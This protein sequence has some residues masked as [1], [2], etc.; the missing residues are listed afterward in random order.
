MQQG[1]QQY[2]KKLTSVGFIFL[3][4]VEHEIII[5]NLSIT[6]LF[7]E[8]SP[9][10][11]L[12]DIHDLFASI[13][14]YSASVDLVIP[15]M[16]LAAEAEVVRADMVDGLIYMGLE[17]KNISYDVEGFIY[18]RESYRKK[19]DG[20]GNIEFAGQNYQFRTRNVSVDGLMILINESVVLEEGAVAKFDFPKL[21]LKGEVEVIWKDYD[22]DG[23]TVIGLHYIH[24]TKSSVKGIPVFA[25]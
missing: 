1:R 25:N 7:I 15:D 13:Q 10:T 2:R 12:I 19:M 3:A 18:K 20:L 21:D 17:F 23:N 5:R 4:G 16:R 24:M 9:N 11:E 14:T 6:G 8:L 22:N